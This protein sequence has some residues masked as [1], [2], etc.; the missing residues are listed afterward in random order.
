MAFEHRDRARDEGVRHAELMCC[1]PE[2]LLLCDADEYTHGLNLVH[3]LRIFP[4]RLIDY[5]CVFALRKSK[6]NAAQP[7]Y[8]QRVEKRGFSIALPIVHD[9]GYIRQP[10][11]RIGLHKIGI[12]RIA[13]QRKR[14]R[15]TPESG[16]SF[17]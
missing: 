11:K 17:L 1:A 3:S 16:M 5:G 9:S 12:T 13:M 14:R 15:M 2:A 7:L 8:R 6:S 4:A 10:E